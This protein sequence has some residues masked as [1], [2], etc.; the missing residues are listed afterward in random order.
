MWIRRLTGAATFLSRKTFLNSIFDV[1]CT[2]ALK[3]SDIMRE[4][5]IIWET[6]SDRISIT[7]TLWKSLPNRTNVFQINLHVR[8]DHAHHR[9]TCV[10]QFKDKSSWHPKMA[11][12]KTFR[13]K[14]RAVFWSIYWFDYLW[15][16]ILSSLHWR[17]QHVR[18]IHW[19]D[20]DIITCKLEWKTSFKL[21]NLNKYPK[22]YLVK[23]MH[24]L[25][26]TWCEYEMLQNQIWWFV[27]L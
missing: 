14:I 21:N 23:N 13:I 12:M 17:V 18:F 2:W 19:F 20:F 1:S 25:E 27:L 3:E 5:E 7:F 22:L 10:D 16:W 9:T 26:L 4:C 11:S 24:R 6:K 15:W 8:N